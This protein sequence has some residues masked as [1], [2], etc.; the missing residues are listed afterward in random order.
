[1]KCDE[2][3]NVYIK[4]KRLTRISHSSLHEKRPAANVKLTVAKKTIRRKMSINSRPYSHSQN[5]IKNIAVD[6]SCNAVF[7]YTYFTADYF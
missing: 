1:M 7:F 5:R 2:N 4:F 6:D 3:R